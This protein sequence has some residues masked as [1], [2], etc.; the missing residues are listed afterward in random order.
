[1]R[2]IIAG[3]RSVD[4]YHIVKLVVEMSGFEITEVVCGEARGVDKLGK[5]WAT[6]QGI[7]V[8]PFRPKWKDIEGKPA[9][10]IKENRYGKYYVLA[11]RERNAAMAE[12]ADALIAIWDEISSGT[13]HM[14][15]EAT[16]RGLKVFVAYSKL[17]EMLKDRR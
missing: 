11:G 10:L 15:E 17:Y 9:H 8:K 12:Y 4:D 6:E 1:M 16:T 13:Q 2:T 3:S 7:P 14:I 5:R